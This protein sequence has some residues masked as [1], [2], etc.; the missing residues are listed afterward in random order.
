MCRNMS[1]ADLQTAKIDMLRRQLSGRGITD[2][3]VLAAMSKVPRERFLPPD[4]ISRLM[5]IVPWASTAV[6][7][8]AS[9]IWWR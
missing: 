9:R 4:C 5:P 6:K 3:R 1:D 7:P 2:R 8:S